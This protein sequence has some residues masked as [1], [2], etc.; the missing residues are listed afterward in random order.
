MFKKDEEEYPRIY[1]EWSDASGDDGS[2]ID[3]DYLEPMPPIACR[4]AGFI[5]EETKEYVTICSSINK[6]QIMGRL[7]VPKAMITKRK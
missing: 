4:T 1:I 6:N 7:T 5:L 2:W 3:K